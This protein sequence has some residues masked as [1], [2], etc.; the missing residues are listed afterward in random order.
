MESSCTP[1]MHRKTQQVFYGSL[2]RKTRVNCHH[3]APPQT[4]FSIYC[5]PL[6]HYFSDSSRSTYFT[7]S[8]VHLWVQRIQP[9]IHAILHSILSQPITAVTCC[10][11]AV[12][13]S[14]FSVTSISR[15]S[16][17]PLKTL[18][19]NYTSK[20]RNNG[21]PLCQELPAAWNCALECVELTQIS[22]DHW[23]TSPTSRNTTIMTSTAC[24]SPQSHSSEPG[25]LRSLLPMDWYNS[26]RT[27]SIAN[28]K[29]PKVCYMV[30]CLWK[31]AGRYICHDQS[32]TSK[33]INSKVCHIT[34]FNSRL[35]F[36][37]YGS[38]CL[39]QHTLCDPKNMS[40]HF[41]Q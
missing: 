30:W 25:K 11:T 31:T 2:S 16:W 24:N 5:Q 19:Y 7:F 9:I 20:R 15:G 12:N 37:N 14:S 18:K 22:T 6:Y 13:C 21:K 41:I 36:K 23:A 26:W 10:Y 33:I 8:L 34:L 3:H 38:Q 39:E 4:A 1:M 40:L 17:R 32:W 35:T 29:E 28:H 27:S